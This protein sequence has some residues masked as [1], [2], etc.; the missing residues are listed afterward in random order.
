MPRVSAPQ[1]HKVLVLTLVLCLCALS[2]K[3]NAVVKTV[4]DSCISVD[5]KEIQVVSSRD[6]TTL[7]WGEMNIDLVI[8]GTGVFISREGAGKHLQVNLLQ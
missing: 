3:F 4:S 2:G 6:P 7:P 8:E 1:I 5:G